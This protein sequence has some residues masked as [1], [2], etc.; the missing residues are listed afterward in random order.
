MIENIIENEGTTL[1]DQLISIFFTI[2]QDRSSEKPI[3]EEGYQKLD[4]EMLE[5]Q[6][7]SLCDR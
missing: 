6:K 4:Q 3:P 7:E 5:T 1:T 2:E